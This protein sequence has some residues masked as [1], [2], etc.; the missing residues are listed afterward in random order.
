[1]KHNDVIAILGGMK[2]KFEKDRPAWLA[3]A[4]AEEVSV[5]EKKNADKVAALDFAMKCVQGHK[6]LKRAAAF[7]NENLAF[8]EGD[9]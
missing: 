1:M 7:I 2:S 3:N 8:E 9:E 4:T 6:E 5:F